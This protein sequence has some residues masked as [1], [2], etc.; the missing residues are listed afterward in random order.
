MIGW[1]VADHVLNPGIGIRARPV[2]APC[3]GAVGFDFTVLLA[4]ERDVRFLGRPD[5]DSCMEY[6]GAISGPLLVGRQGERRSGVGRQVLAVGL[7]QVIDEMPDLV[8]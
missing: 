7:D 6:P 5:H 1:I 4:N 2:L 8:E 3:R